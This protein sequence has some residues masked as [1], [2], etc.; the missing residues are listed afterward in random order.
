MLWLAAILALTMRGS[1][2]ML[3]SCAW[4]LLWVEWTLFSL[5]RKLPVAEWP[6]QLYL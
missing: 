4:P 2:L 3:I 5:R 6:K 1:W